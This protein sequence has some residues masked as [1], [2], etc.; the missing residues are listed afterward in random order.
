MTNLTE[1]MESRLLL[2]AKGQL[3]SPPLI[4]RQ[5]TS[6]G[7]SSRLWIAIPVLIDQEA[8]LPRYS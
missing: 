4:N 8:G 7:S 5:L 1:A 2:G 3:N 6:I